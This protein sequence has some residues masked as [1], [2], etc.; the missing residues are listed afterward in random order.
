MLYSDPHKKQVTMVLSMAR[1]GASAITRALQVIGVS[2]GD[3]LVES[4]IKNPLS[5]WE[6]YDV[7]YKVNRGLM[8]LLD[9]P[10]DGQSLLKELSAEQND[11]LIK[12]KEY[13]QKIM[14][15]RLHDSDHWAFKDVNTTTLLPFWQMVINEAKLDDSYIIALRNPLA[16]A[17]S[18]AKHSAIEIEAGLLEWLRNLIIAIDMT[19]G[20]RRIVVSY[21]LLL[22]EPEM[23]LQRMAKELRAIE[24]LD[25]QQVESYKTDFLGQKQHHYSYNLEDLKNN[26]AIK[27]VPLC[28]R[29]Y[30]LFLQL[31]RDESSFVD[32]DFYTQWQEIKDEFEH[33][34]PLYHYARAL[35]KENHLLQ[36]EL[37]VI[38]KSIPWRLCY[39]LRMVENFVRQRRRSAR[40]ERR[41]VKAY[42]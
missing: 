17:Y 38:R 11:E 40:S 18:N 6:D 32:G 34:Y 20:K 10:W 1:S 29:V 21:E 28:L 5:V 13:A 4:T 37:R 12:Y 2:L 22:E 42:G 7:T 27:A 19:H 8:R 23:Q 15:S 36:R 14:A 9:Y 35:I 30:E 33:N 24:E 16:C 25:A 39:P 31:A 41:L 3:N 26:A